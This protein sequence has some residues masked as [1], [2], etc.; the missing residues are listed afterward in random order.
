VHRFGRHEQ[1][2]TG[3]QRRRLLTFQVVLQRAFEDVDD[4]FARMLVP[5]EGRFRADVDAVLDDLSSW[6]TQIVP[7]EIGARDSRQLPHRAA[8]VNL[9]RV[10]AVV[11]GP[12]DGTPVASSSCLL[13]L[14][15]S[16]RRTI[17]QWSEA[18][19]KLL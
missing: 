14:R 12:H 16:R 5:D 6:G 10:A 19:A 9:L 1:D 4:L 13:R 18:H 8:H 3:V 17:T 7:L 15:A 11:P 2:V